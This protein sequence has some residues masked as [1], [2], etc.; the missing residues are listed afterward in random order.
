MPPFGL[1]VVTGVVVVGS[2]VVV[3]PP[4]VVVTETITA[5]LTVV[6]ATSLPSVSTTSRLTN[7]TGNVPS[8]FA[9]KFRVMI[10][11]FAF[12]LLLSS[13]AQTTILP[14]SLMT[15]SPV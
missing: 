11:P 6:T 7:S 15:G 10:T 8:S 9:T 14:S 1:E 12:W 5:P 13:D 3:V 4:S 2:V